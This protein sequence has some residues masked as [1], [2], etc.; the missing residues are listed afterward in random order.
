MFY[1]NCAIVH[2]VMSEKNGFCRKLLTYRFGLSLRKNPAAAQMCISFDILLLTGTFG[3]ST[4]ISSFPL[5][6]SCKTFC[7]ESSV[8]VGGGAP[9]KSTS[10]RYSVEL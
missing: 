10:G 2:C 8:G 4:V 3:D 9:R 7:I 6:F 5:P 1:E